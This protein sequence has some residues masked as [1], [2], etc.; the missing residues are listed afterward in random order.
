[1]RS[2]PAPPTG[3][4]GAAES[5]EVIRRL[6]SDRASTHRPATTQCPQRGQVGDHDKI[7]VTGLPRRDAVPIDSVHLYVNRQQV[8]APFGAVLEDVFKKEPGVDPLALEAALQVD[9]G[10][11]HG[12]DR[13]L[14]Y[15][16]PER[17]DAQWTIGH[18]SSLHYE[19]AHP[20]AFLPSGA[21]AGSFTIALHAQD[22]GTARPSV[23]KLLPKVGGVE[24]RGVVVPEA[25]AEASCV[26]ENMRRAG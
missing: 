14:S 2:T 11:N 5:A 20:K 7:A 6:G 1:M 18:T 26:C 12:V 8:V 3:Q 4:V 17:I 13:A 10:D 16:G 22:L 15:G 25:M 21:R 23:V 24:R 9:D 19:L